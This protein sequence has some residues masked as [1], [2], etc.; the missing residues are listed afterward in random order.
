MVD[1]KHV[2]DRRKLRFETFGDVLRDVDSLADAERRGK[3]RATGNWQ[4]GQAVG[5]IA[6]WASA[7]FDGY[8][9]MRRPPWLF[10]VM[11]KMFKTK[12]LNSSL[13][14]GFS[15]PGAAA[16]TYG[17][18]LLP[19]DEAVARL[20]T[21]FDRLDEKCPAVDNPAFGPLTHDE[22]KKLNLRHSEL[23]LSF[24]HPG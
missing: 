7:P 21:A 10:G 8:P 20:T 14:S 18:D 3:L 23:H 5:H 17:V 2:K 11:L 22:W 13:P 9:T 4:L 16:G 1:T 6:Y 15:I 19:V 24:F 12:I